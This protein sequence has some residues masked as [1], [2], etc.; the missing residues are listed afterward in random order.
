[1]AAPIPE[2]APV[3]ATWVGRGAVSAWIVILPAKHG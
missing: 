1:M 3:T 2:E